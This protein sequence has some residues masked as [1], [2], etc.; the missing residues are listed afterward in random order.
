M[1][2]GFIGSVNAFAVPYALKFRED[3]HDVKYISSAHSDDFLNRPE[4]QF[5][6]KIQHPYP[7]WIC[8]NVVSESLVTR[9]FPEFFHKKTISFMQDRDIIFLN[10]Y[11]L[12]ISRHLPRSAI[13]IALCSGSDLDVMCSYKAAWHN[14]FNIRKIWM[15]P[16]SLI[17][18]LRWTFLQRNGLKKVS[19]ISYFPRGLNNEGDKLIFDRTKLNQNIAFIPRYDVDFESAGVKFAG[20]TERDLI[21]ILVPVRFCIN[22][23]DGNSFEYKGNDRIIEGLA[24]YAKRNSKVQICFF[25]KGPKDDLA[26]AKALCKNYDLDNNIRWLP[27]QPLN[28]LLDLY[29]ESDVII[30]QVGSHWMGAVGVYGMYTGKAVIANW[31]PEVFSKVFDEPFPVLQASTSDEVYEQLVRCE[32]FEFRRDLGVAANKFANN[33]LDIRSTYCRYK[34]YIENIL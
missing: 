27:S 13:L 20:A 1:K 3:G 14:S 30:D 22:P 29:Y 19:C 32:N 8:E 31:R 26:L 2:I 18:H 9:A 5:P 16:L 28:K 7:N 23:S 33:N 12:S 24:K 34:K 6:N 21:K 17:L 4:H 10:D 15:W 11:G 25:L